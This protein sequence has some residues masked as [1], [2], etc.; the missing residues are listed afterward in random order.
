MKR[1]GFLFIIIASLF[2]SLDGLIRRS[3][4]SL[5][6]AT[7]V[8][9]EHVFGV[10]ITLPFLP[11][12][13]KE[14]K[15]LRKVDWLIVFILTLTA[16]VLATI[17]YTSALAKVNYINFSV[18]ILLQQT[19]PIFSILLAALLLKEKITP[20]FLIITFIG[21]ISAYVLAFPNLLPNFT[22]QP[23]ELSAAILAMG[24]AI[25][26]GGSNTL[27]KMVLKRI[28]HI[29]TAILRF[30][31]AIPLAFIV[32]KI[33]HQTIPL[34]LIT[35]TQWLS[36]L[37]IALTSGMVAFIIFYKGLQYTQVK[38]ATFLKLSWPVFATIL[39]WIV[40]KERLNLVQIIA[41][42]VLSADIIVLSLDKAT[43]EETK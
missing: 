29:A 22:N 35:P 13:L 30:S 28:S 27:G 38:T 40:L 1:F 10:L 4:Y 26:W 43:H 20:K 15:K 16:S 36:M 32:A 24:A 11:K 21:L 18:V 12:V 3:L 41:A 9:L 6:P 8:M 39:G 34:S 25:F 42:I 17:F 33:T 5:P 23:E 19:Q 31:L 14:Y 2:W 37:G 7:V